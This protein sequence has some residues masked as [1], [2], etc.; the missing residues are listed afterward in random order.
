MYC[1]DALK[2]REEGSSFEPPCAMAGVVSTTC[3]VILRRV[4]RHIVSND[5]TG[6]QSLYQAM[7]KVQVSTVFL[8]W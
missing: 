7:G 6:I 8:P 1:L 5:N 3:S 4:G 2:S